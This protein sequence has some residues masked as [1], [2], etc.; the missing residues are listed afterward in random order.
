M[1]QFFIEST[2]GRFLRINQIGI[3]LGGSDPSRFIVEQGARQIAETVQGL[4][5]SNG[6]DVKLIVK[7]E[8]TDYEQH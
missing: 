6:V 7:K 4:L 2:D 5:A 8:A 3:T 1:N